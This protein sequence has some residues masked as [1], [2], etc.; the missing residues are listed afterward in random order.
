MVVE[1]VPGDDAVT[2]VQR[3]SVPD[4]WGRSEEGMLVG[5]AVAWSLA[6]ALRIPNTD[7]RRDAF[8]IALPGVYTHRIGLRYPKAVPQRPA[9]QDY[10]EGDEHFSLRMR[11][12]TDPGGIEVTSQVALKV[13]EIAPRDWPAYTARLHKAVSHLGATVKVP[14]VSPAGIEQ[15]KADVKALEDALRSGRIKPVTDRQREAHLQLLWLDHQIAGGRL[16]GPLLAQALAERAI[17]NDDLGRPEAAGRD[18]ERALELA[19]DVPET[20]GGAARNAALRGHAERALALADAVLR[21]RPGD[22]N[23][24]RTRSLAG[25]VARDYAAA[26]D[27][28]ERVLQD[29]SAWRR[30]YPLVMW[31]LMQ[32][33]T[34]GDASRADRPS[35]ESDLPTGWPRPLVDWALGER[36]ADDLLRAARSGGMPAERLCEAYFYLGEQADARGDAGLAAEYFRKAVEQG[37]TE[38]I[39]DGLA[40]LRLAALQA[41]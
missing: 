29:A 18:F 21:Q 23:A 10:D 1:P 33:R 26:R 35:R 41:R 31:A 36:S 25:Y 24:L 16:A 27:D 17:Q 34:G 28:A 38:F 19:P 9:S 2:L 11:A 39:E 32:Q 3:F 13:D 12:D 5:E 7:P 22:T 20:L 8:A 30:G 6:T 4:F 37:V 40:R 14:P 15:F